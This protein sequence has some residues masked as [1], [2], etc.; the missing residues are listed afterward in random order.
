MF[1]KPN[2]NINITPFLTLSIPLQLQEKMRKGIEWH[3]MVD[4]LYRQVHR[5]DKVILKISSYTL[6]TTL[7]TLFSLFEKM[8]KSKHFPDVEVMILR[9]NLTKPLRIWNIKNIDDRRYWHAVR[10]DGI[11]LESVQKFIQEQHPRVK[12]QERFFPFDP[13][14]KAIIAND[15]L[16]FFGLYVVDRHPKTNEPGLTA[17]DYLGAK[18]ELTQLSSG[19]ILEELINWFNRTWKT[20]T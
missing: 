9:P 15:C 3:D 17:L 11:V 8:S 20:L 5:K 18:T 10:K 6:Q 13:C 14:V 2:L 1:E 19:C 16:A 12:F 7:Y 4:L